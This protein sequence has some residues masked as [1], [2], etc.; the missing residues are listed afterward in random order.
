[1]KELEK[2]S[3]AR[4]IEDLLLAYSWKIATKKLECSSMKLKS[5][6][7]IKDVVQV[8]VRG[9]PGCTYAVY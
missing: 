5:A 9:A 6:L 1:L 3:M 7:V 2:K 8:L 4:H